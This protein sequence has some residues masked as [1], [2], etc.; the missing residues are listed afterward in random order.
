MLKLLKTEKFGSIQVLLLENDIGRLEVIVD[1][2]I[3][4][5]ALSTSY[6]CGLNCAGCDMP[7]INKDIKGANVSVEELVEQVKY[8]LVS[9]PVMKDTVYLIIKFSHIGEPTINPYILVAVDEIK[10]LFNT[11]VMFMLNTVMPSKDCNHNIYKFFSHWVDRGDTF[12]NVNCYS[13]D[14]SIRTKLLGDSVAD[15]KTISEQVK[16]DTQKIFLT[17]Y[18]QYPFDPNVIIELFDPIHF[19]IRFINP[20]EKIEESILL[21]MAKELWNKGFD[22]ESY[23]LLDKKQELIRGCGNMLY[24][25]KTLIISSP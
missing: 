20:V 7:G 11:R 18:T 21:E 14:A 22:I 2:S 1:T 23:G 19:R 24:Q 9:E 12:F 16:C 5:I 15:L 6:G 4:T 8:A 25:T 13:T 17:F 10:K 3:S